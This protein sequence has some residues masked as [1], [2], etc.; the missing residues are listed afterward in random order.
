MP[1]NRFVLRVPLDA[2]R[3]P[4]FR[5]DRAV[6]VLAWS[7]QCAPQERLVR[8]S[9]DKK[10]TAAFEFEAA[11]QESLRIALGPETAT[12]F[13]LQ[14]L[15]TIS[16]SVPVSS[17]SGKSEV[18]LPAVQISAYYWWWWQHWQQSFKVTGRVVSSRGVPVIG[19]TV[20]AFDIDAWWW[21]TAR[22]RVGDAMTDEDGSFAIEF[23]R[24]SGWWPWWWWATRE[25]QANAELVGRITAFV[26]QYSKFGALGAPT[27]IPGLEVF[28][29][30]LA[31][32][33]R[34]MPAKL[35]LM[36]PTQGMGSGAIDP[37]ALES[38]RDR[39]VEILPRNFP[40]PVWPWSQWAPWED[41]GAN[42]IF[43][44]TD[45]CGDEATVLLNESVSE[46]RWDIPSA[47][48]VTLTTHEARFREKRLGWTLVDCLFS[49][50][51]GQVW[52]G[53]GGEGAAVGRPA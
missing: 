19:A 13:E 51:R 44:V 15:Q 3:V 36:R 34:P 35:S 25:W 28:Q 24:T 10:G 37:A 48:D 11:P 46:A 47:L 27:A 49:G 6:R 40:L 16:V 2:S 4:E 7:K 31:S 23:K 20:A 38:L 21:W 18:T 8:F 41:C 32:S 9:K 53:T 14:R 42:L 39:L 5:P 1:E 33:S 43:K 26:G 12:A 45:T 50:N 22:E 52:S 29:P 17:W 30:L